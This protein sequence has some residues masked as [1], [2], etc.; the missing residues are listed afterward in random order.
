[1]INQVIKKR[2]KYEKKSQSNIDKKNFIRKSKNML[3]NA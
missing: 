3:N 1:M 2:M